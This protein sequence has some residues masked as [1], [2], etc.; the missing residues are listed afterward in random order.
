MVVIEDIAN[1]LGILLEKIR[2]DLLKKKLQYI[3]GAGLI[4]GAE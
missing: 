4:E 2:N 3:E 1:N